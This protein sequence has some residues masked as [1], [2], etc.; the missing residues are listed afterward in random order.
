MD[1]LN[2]NWISSHEFWFPS[3]TS[4]TDTQSRENFT[5]PQ[6]SDLWAVP[7]FAVLFHI[8]RKLYE[9]YICTFLLSN[10]NIKS[11]R[12]LPSSNAQL[13]AVYKTQKSPPDKMITGLSK[14]LDMNVKQIEHWFR[15]RRNLD[16]PTVVTKFAES[17]WR[18]LFYFSIFTFGMFM[19]FKSPWL[20][21]NVQCWTDYPQQSLPTWLYYYYMLEAGF[22]LSLLFTIAEDV[23]RKDF[24]IQVIHHVSTLF[25]IIFSY[26]CNFVRVG[27]LVLAVHDVSDIFLEFGKSILYANYKSLADNLFV[28]FAAVFIF[29]RLFIYPFYVIHTSAIKIRVLKPFPAYYFFNGLLVVLQILHIYWASIILKMAVKF[30]KGDKMADERSDDEESVSD[31]ED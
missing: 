6:T 1:L 19:L 20:W 7:A 30:I 28:I 4:K 21:D 14:Q 22:Y 16:R 26:M 27:S 31:D 10:L 15:M 11:E 23:K 17:S 29:T 12:R 25:L 2:L 8:L 9:H 3:G 5:F 24:P 13:E 18:F